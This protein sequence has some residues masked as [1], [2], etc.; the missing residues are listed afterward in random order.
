MLTN[1][2]AMLNNSAKQ[3]RDACS[4]LHSPIFDEDEE[5]REIVEEERNRDHARDNDW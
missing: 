2:I 4:E 5:G 3:L 1:T